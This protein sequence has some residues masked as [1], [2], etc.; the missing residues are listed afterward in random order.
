MKAKSLRRH[1]KNSRWEEGKKP[2]DRVPNECSEVTKVSNILQRGY[3]QGSGES[4]WYLWGKKEDE[5]RLLPR[6]KKIEEFGE[7]QRQRGPGNIFV[8]QRIKKRCFDQ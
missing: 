7:V 5:F 8:L 4:S 2:R 6:K 3:G 1:G